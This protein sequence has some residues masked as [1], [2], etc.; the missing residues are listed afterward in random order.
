MNIAAIVVF[1]PKEGKGVEHLG[2]SG[3][4]IGN[5]AGGQKEAVDKTA[6]VGGRKGGG[7]FVG[8]G[9][10]PSAVAVAAEGAIKTVV[11]A[12]IALE[13]FEESADS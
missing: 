4:G 12:V 10:R 9:L 6:L 2:H 3:F 5:D 7:H 8:S 13:N 1:P 11:L